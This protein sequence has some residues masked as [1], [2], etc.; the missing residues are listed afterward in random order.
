MNKRV[1]AA[2]QLELKADAP[3]RLAR[4]LPWGQYRLTVT[5][6]EA[7][8]STSTKFD[9]GWYGDDDSAD[10]PAPDTLRVASDKQN[11]A[12]GETARL[13]IESTSAGQAPSRGRDRPPPGQRRSN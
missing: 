5:D 4:H 10:E 6:R 7:N 11:Y 2:D 3:V 8:T 9:V 13:R 1:V 12:P